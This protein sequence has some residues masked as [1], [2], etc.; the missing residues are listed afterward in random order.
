MTQTT[1][2]RCLKFVVGGRQAETQ[3]RRPVDIYTVIRKY[4]VMKTTL[5]L[6]DDIF[7]E[8][9][10]RAA[11]RGQSFGKF[12]EQ[13]LRRMLDESESE[14]ASRA[15][16]WVGELPPVPAAASSALEQVIS[17]PDFRQVDKSMW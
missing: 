7:R 15:S 1:E 9:K 2:T 14:T 4:G 8:A 10:A 12:L 3:G 6:P 17:A 5:V 13:G 11:L 16:C